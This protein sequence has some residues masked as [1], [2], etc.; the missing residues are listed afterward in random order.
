[1][2]D[3]MKRILYCLMTLLVLMSVAN[4]TSRQ[5]PLTTTSG[6]FNDASGFN[7]ADSIISDVGDTRDHRRTL[8]VID[9][10]EKTGELSLPKLIF[11]RT[12]SYN[13][14]GQYRASLR[15]Y[16]QLADIDVKS[17]T[18]QADMDTYI[19][20]YNNY[21]RVL[22]DMKRY[23]L[24]LREANAADRKLR[25]VGYNTFLDHHDVA[26]I[27][28]ECQLYLGQT[29]LAA[30]SFQKSLQGIHARL[31]KYHDPLDYRECQKTMNA[32]AKCYMETECYDEVTPWIMAQDSLFAIADKHPR[33]DS[34]F[35]DE[36]KA[37]IYYSKALLAQAQGRDDE[38]EQAFSEYQTTHLAK[39]LGS[40]IHS[41]EYL[42]EAKRYEEAA[43]NYHLLDHFLLESG[44]KANFEN[45]GRYMLPK[46][47]ANLLAGH[48]DT[49]L[50]AATVVA[51][52]YDSAVVRQRRIDSDLLTTFY[53]TE[54]KERQ[55][56]EQRAELSQQRLWTVVFVALIFV[57]FFI[58]YAIQRR[59]AYRKLDATNRQLVL[60]NERAEESS[61][62]KTKFIQQ[63]SHEVRTP[64]NILSGFSQV[65]ATPDIEIESEELQVISQKIVEN[66]DRITKLVDKMLDLS[67]VNS[68]ADIE[69]HDTVTAAELALM[70]A[71]E[72]GIREVEHLDFQLQISPEAE[73]LNIVTNR[74]SAVKAL[75]MLLD[76]AIKF[77]HPQVFQNHQADHQKA[78]VT[79]GVSGIQQQVVFVVEDTGIGIP[80]EQA[81]NIFT[82]FVQLDDY[83]DGTGIGLSIARSLAR[84]MKGDVILDTTYTDGARFV[85]T[86]CNIN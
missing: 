24:A 12:I 29:A 71:K 48:L 42:I 63:I 65:L 2:F 38:A 34:V 46:F 53:D 40:I 78:R 58:I 77:T 26:Q 28:G 17:L 39:Q 83:S 73:S 52:Y 50:R 68:Q 72:S 61:R 27:I 76:N 70:A 82:E 44:Y 32:I 6:G 16:S 36:M 20:S 47:R 23:D 56:A 31:A 60:A 4:C 75:V 59:R 69:C 25:S 57:L 10:L 64:L 11:Y 13:M 45:F 15:L 37:D 18:N 30:Q 33:R 80:P 7:R 43:Q 1:M 62:M 84:Q 22:C 8:E 9:S 79:L 74:K 55:I 67:L 54:G 85:M 41:S 86:L 3:D 66:S 35:I 14:L 49:A 19:Y 81:E 5:N 51:D 21:V